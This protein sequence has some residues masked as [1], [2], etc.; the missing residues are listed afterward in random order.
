MKAIQP[1]LKK[2]LFHIL[3][4]SIVLAVLLI[5]VE[6][7]LRFLDLPTSQLSNTINCMADE[8]NYV[9]KPNAHVLFTGLHDEL[10][11]TVIWH[12]NPQGIRENKFIP[13]KTSGNCRVATYGDSETFGWP[14]ITRVLFRNKLN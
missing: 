11:D 3:Y 5:A 4:S 9:L 2:I 13:P 6:V 1:I 8:R 10:K 12:T 14:L 7:L